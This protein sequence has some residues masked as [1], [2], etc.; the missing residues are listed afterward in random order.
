[1]ALMTI[2]DDAETVGIPVGSAP[3]DRMSA[4]T[5]AIGNPW[6]T[7]L[8]DCHENQTNGIIIML[9]HF[10]FVPYLSCLYSLALLESC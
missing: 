9:F 1:M 8:F 6:N 4:E 10:H 3:P 2:A 7:G 5:Q